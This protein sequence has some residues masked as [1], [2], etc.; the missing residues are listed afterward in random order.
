VPQRF[1]V[2]LIHLGRRRA[3]CASDPFSAPSAAE[4]RD[5]VVNPDGTLRAAVAAPSKTFAP[6][7]SR[8][9]S[10]WSRKTVAYGFAP[11][12][13]GRRLGRWAFG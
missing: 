6:A 3:R 11:F 2:E 4:A 7:Q 13:K 10:H 1:H 5:L 9:R 12:P 8:N